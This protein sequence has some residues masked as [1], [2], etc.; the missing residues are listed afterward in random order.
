MS[1]RKQKPFLAH[2][3]SVKYLLMLA[4]STLFLYLGF[5]KIADGDVL[6]FGEWYSRWLGLIPIGF[7]L[8]AFITFWVAY[9][10]ER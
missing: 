6:I 1:T 4:I 7:G 9:F 8:P 3:F 5:K 10:Q 2:L